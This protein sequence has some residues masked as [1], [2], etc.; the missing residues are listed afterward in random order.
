MAEAQFRRAVVPVSLLALLVLYVHACV[1]EPIADLRAAEVRRVPASALPEAGVRRNS[2]A[3]RGEI[4]WKLSLEGDAD[5]I[6]QVRQHELNSYA[7]VVRCDQRDYG[8][9]AF[10]PYVGQVRVSAQNDA[11]E[12]LSPTSATLRYDIYLAEAGRYRSQADFN[13]PMP[14]YDLATQ[15]LPL[16]VTI[17]GGAMHG[18]YNRSNE[19]HVRLGLSR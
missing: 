10:G 9:D 12:G 11:L 3:R 16:C 17:A 1:P 4:L 18:A 19:V 7:T 8:I 6:S 13:A 14:S 15:R 2:L 5:W